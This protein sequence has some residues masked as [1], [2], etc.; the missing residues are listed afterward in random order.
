[1]FQEL[2]QCF[3]L[4][5]S[6]SYCEAKHQSFDIHHIFL[7]PDLTTYKDKNVETKK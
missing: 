1:M 2:L 6:Y 4:C 5:S 7:V 3:T